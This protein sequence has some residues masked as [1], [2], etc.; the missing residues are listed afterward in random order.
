[1]LIN[2][3]ALISAMII[4]LLTLPFIYKCLLD[5][6]CVQK[7]Y[8]NREVPIG[9]GIIFVLNQF[10]LCYLFGNLLDIR[11]SIINIY[12]MFLVLMAFIGIIDD[13]IGSKDIKGFKGHITSLL[14]GTLTTG[15]LKAIVGGISALVISLSI[16]NSIIELVTDLILIS[17]FTNL[18][19]LFDL[20]P[21]RAIKTFLVAALL[22]LYTSERFEFEI[23][24][25]LAIGITL[26]YLPL[27]L[28]GK[29]MLGDVGSNSLGFTLGVYCAYTM[30]L[31]YKVI[32]CL[33]LIVLHILSEFY[34]YSRIIENNKV[35]KYL[36]DLGK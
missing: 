7:N 19:N 35:L 16:Y 4:T 14:N 13:L 26:I 15:G 25:F 27:D 22:L 1:M 36:D 12:I 2:F 17:L 23:I 21:G 9:L 18:I 5:N 30:S 10:F 3:I 32:Y 34:S 8:K 11:D 24:I 6:G 28:R 20:R 29:G 31:R 33:F